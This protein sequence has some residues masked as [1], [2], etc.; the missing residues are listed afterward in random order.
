MRKK[1][2]LLLIFILI[3]GSFY[4]F[5]TS[6]KDE[7]S[8]KKLVFW[9][10]QLKPIWEKQLSLI[11]NEF[12]KKH[13]EAKVVWVDI[14]IQEAQKRTL[15]SI[16]SST[17]PDLVN[18][19]P[20][21]SN[22]L[23]QRNTLETFDNQ[24]VSQFH[25][26]LVNKLKYQNQIYALPFYATSPVTIYNQTVFSKCF[27]NQTFPKTY[28]EL[29]KISKELYTCSNL[30]P[31]AINLNENDTLAKI[32]NK[33]NVSNLKTETNQQKTVEIFSKFNEMYKAGF[34]PKDTLTINHR[35]MIEKYMSNQAIATTA[36]SNF[37]NMVKQNALD[38]Y[39]NSA[40]A[41]QLTGLNGGYDIALMNLIIPKKAPNKELALE[42][43]LLLTNK[44][45]QI[46]LAK[47][48]NVLPANKFA[49][50]DDY[51]KICS[52]DLIDKSRCES[53]KQLSKL[54]N[55]TFGDE[56]KK[57]I[58]EYI[59]KAIEDILLNENSDK[60]YIQSKVLDLSKLLKNLI[61]D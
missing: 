15:A 17:P 47:T 59:N 53:T 35:E 45:N 33:Y 34:L 20:E 36:G 29:F 22:I 52:D 13:P 4:F 31:L 16:L 2:F 55:I 5:N 19:N 21:F 50:E 37:I 39:Q 46:D 12:E 57:A 3:L 30:A 51:F 61:K 32:L 43:A 60:K 42:F 14:P 44:E 54:S 6:K 7:D 28:D 10:I 1:I 11:I 26:N 41:T 24:A 58:N 9:S 27:P 40:I 38:T 8:R 23:A 49:L 18:L 56:N 25:P 48:T